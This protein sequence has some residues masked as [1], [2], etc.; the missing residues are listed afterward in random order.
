[1]IN[2][3]LALRHARLLLSIGSPG[4]GS[5]ANLLGSTLVVE[6]GTF[7]EGSRRKQASEKCLLPE[8]PCRIVAAAALP[9]QEIIMRT[10]MSHIEVFRSFQGN[11]FTIPVEVW[12]TPEGVCARSIANVFYRDGSRVILLLAAHEDP[13]LDEQEIGLAEDSLWVVKHFD[14][15]VP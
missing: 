2:R 7:V 8:S 13:Q 10:L 4:P 14:P 3:A 12:D 15:H 5:S 11:E 9:L 1:M 6:S